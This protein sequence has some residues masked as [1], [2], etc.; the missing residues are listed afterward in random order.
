MVTCRVSNSKGGR[1]PALDLITPSQIRHKKVY[2]R[3]LIHL[4]NGSFN[5]SGFVDHSIA[6][7]RASNKTAE[8]FNSAVT[9]FPRPCLRRYLEFIGERAPRGVPY[10]Y[11][12]PPFITS[13][14]ERVWTLTEDSGPLATFTNVVEAY[15]VM[16]GFHTFGD[17]HEIAIIYRDFMR[18][19]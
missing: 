7:K 13:N 18:T 11:Y 6:W 14:P 17:N 19:D 5:V 2:I 8:Q 16:K 1:V 9:C 12:K 3:K 15:L 4:S 10:Q